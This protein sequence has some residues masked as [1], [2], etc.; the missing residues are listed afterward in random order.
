MPRALQDST[1]CAAPFTAVLIGCASLSPT[2]LSALWTLRKALP[3]SEAQG[4]M[5]LG[6]RASDPKLSA[7]SHE[8]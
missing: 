3:L 8:A 1:L 5:I 2:A 6:R 7:L 4:S